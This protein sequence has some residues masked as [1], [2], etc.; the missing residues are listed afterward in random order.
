MIISKHDYKNNNSEAGTYILVKI[1]SHNNLGP[2]AK[3]LKRKRVFEHKRDLIQNNL[4]NALVINGNK[5]DQNFDLKMPHSSVEIKKKQPL[6]CRCQLLS[7][8]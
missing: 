6:V 3:I 1:A 7:K 8:Y 5:F 4:T 2:H